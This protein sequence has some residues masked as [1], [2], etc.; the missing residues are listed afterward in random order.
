MADKIYVIGEDAAPVPR[1]AAPASRKADARA[2]G[3]APAKAERQPPASPVVLVL[4]YLG[5]PLGAL[6]T[7]R[8]SASRAWRTL[9]LIAGAS[10]LAT[11]LTWR[12]LPGWLAVHP[13]VA[14]AWPAGVLAA[15]TLGSI[16]WARGVAWAQAEVRVERVPRRLRH[17]LTGGLFGFL[18]PGLA[19]TLV[20]RPRRAALILGLTGPFAAFV[21]ITFRAQDLWQ[22]LHG[23]SRLSDAHLELA[24]IGCG[25]LAAMAGLAWLLQALDGL[26]E[27]S[28]SRRPL[29]SWVEGLAMLLVILGL[30]SVLTFERTRTAAELDQVAGRLRAAELEIL[31]LWLWRTATLVD[32]GDPVYAL[33]TAELYRASGKDAAAERIERRLASRWR[34]YEAHVP[35]GDASVAQA[36]APAADGSAP[37]ATSRLHVY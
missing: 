28:L 29:G 31:P 22:T 27:A 23:T 35:R 19:H 6:A 36:E 37:H 3:V 9:A 7:A 18:L 32:A 4:A 10:W 5:G 33:R 11:A 2:D 30:A 15:A 8:G 24:L 12:F 1:R 21:L 16:V 25:I 13:V 17:P 14:L 26:R 20:Q 34:A